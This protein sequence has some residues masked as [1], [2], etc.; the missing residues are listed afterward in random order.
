[1]GTNYECKLLNTSTSLFFYK[2]ANF[3]GHS[4]VN[5]PDK[6]KKHCFHDGSFYESRK[7]DFSLLIS[8]KIIENSRL[9]LIESVD[10]LP[11]NKFSASGL[12]ERK[13]KP[14]PKN[15]VFFIA[16]EQFKMIKNK[17]VNT[18]RQRSTTIFSHIIA[19]LSLFKA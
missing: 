8:S 11:V 18:L 2:F 9:A 6:A 10:H 19:F 13:Q 12:S 4:V 15:S 14:L 1:M 3:Q 17:L 16:G 7:L 5:I